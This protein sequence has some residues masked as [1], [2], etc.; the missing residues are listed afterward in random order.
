[1]ASIGQQSQGGSTGHYKL[2]FKSAVEF[3]VDAKKM[4]EK[5]LHMTFHEEVQVI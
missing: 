5:N 2:G 3:M 1:M 4:V